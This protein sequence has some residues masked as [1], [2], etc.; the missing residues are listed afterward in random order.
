MITTCMDRKEFREMVPELDS[1]DLFQAIQYKIG[2]ER[3][4]VTIHKPD[5]VGYAFK[6]AAAILVILTASFFTITQQRCAAEQV[7]EREPIYFQTNN[8]ENREIT[9]SDGSVVRLN[10]NSE[11]I[12][13]DDLFGCRL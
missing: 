4:K 12:I 2:P 13:S 3:K 6:A 11:V 8:D 1:D 7:V 9:L 5:W 10:K